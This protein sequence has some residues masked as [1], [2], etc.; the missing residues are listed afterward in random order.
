MFTLSL[1][2]LNKFKRVDCKLTLDKTTADLKK[3]KSVKSYIIHEIKI[4]I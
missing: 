3:K 2:S 4:L 1:E